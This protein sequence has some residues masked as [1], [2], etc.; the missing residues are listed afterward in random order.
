MLVTRVEAHVL[1]PAQVL[2]GQIPSDILVN[3][4]ADELAS[5]ERRSGN[6]KIRDHMAKECVRGQQNMASTDMFKC[7]KC[8]M[9]KTT[10]YQ[11]QTRSA[12]EVSGISRWH[13]SCVGLMD[14][15]TV[16]LVQPMTTFVTCVNCGNRWKFC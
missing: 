3:L 4:S 9:N 8:K 14:M 15:S 16:R 11:L 12:D 10:Y 2:M 1:S 6:D 7:G 5:D 13:Q